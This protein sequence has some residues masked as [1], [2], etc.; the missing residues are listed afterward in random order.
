MTSVARLDVFFLGFPRVSPSPGGLTLVARRRSFDFRIFAGEKGTCGERGR[1]E[2]VGGREGGKPQKRRR[3]TFGW[4]YDNLWRHNFYRVKLVEIAVKEA[5]D[6]IA[7]VKLPLYL[8]LAR[9]RAY[10][11]VSLYLFFINCIKIQ[12][13][14]H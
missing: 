10:G 7:D 11:C 4:K 9:A 3:R 5:D 2:A 13:V 14:F 12:R 8:A 6:K 1:R